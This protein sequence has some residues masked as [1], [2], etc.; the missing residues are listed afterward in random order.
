GDACT[1]CGRCQAVCP[2]YMAGTPLNPK[3]VIL[4]IRDS[5]NAY[6][7]FL[8]LGPHDQ[9]STTGNDN[10]AHG[11]MQVTGVRIS[12]GALWACT[13]CR[14]CV[15]ECP[16]LIEHVDAIV[17]M[18]RDLV[19]MEANPPKMLQNTFTNAERAANPWGNRSSRLDW[20]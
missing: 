5:I 15:Q 8:K 9:D 6:Q 10:G 16:V 12:E 20:T 19:L 17:D 11:D 7:G 3:Q 2:A 4:D 18:R 14:A 1:E 13:T